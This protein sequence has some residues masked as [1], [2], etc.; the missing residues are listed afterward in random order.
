LDAP[1]PDPMRLSVIIP[2][3]GSE[4][5]QA[6]VES[7][8]IACKHVDFAVEALIVDDRREKSVELK[9]SH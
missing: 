4:T 5:L 9:V 1:I 8:G 6:C 7:V 3:A 2:H